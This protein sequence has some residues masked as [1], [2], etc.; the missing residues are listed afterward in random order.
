[1]EQMEFV[2]ITG[3]SGAGKSQA[4]KVFEDMGFFCVDNLPAPL[5]PKFAEL[6]R[7]SEGKVR[8]VALVIDIRGDL[9]L[10]ELN[11]SLAQ[12]EEM[13]VEYQILF[14]EASDEVLVSRFKETRRNHPLNPTGAIGEGIK[15]EREKLSDLRGRANQV[16]DTSRLKSA[17]LREEIRQQ[18][19]D[20][21]TKMNVTILSFGYKHGI[22]MDTD[23]LMDVRFI[24]NP[25]Y[26]PHLRAL[27]GREKP[28]QDYVYAQKET[29]EF[30]ERFGGLLLFLLPNYIKEGKTHMMLGIGCTGG[31][32]RSVAL[33]IKLGEI[34]RNNG[35]NVTVR[36]R[37]S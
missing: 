37:D 23:L 31:Q 6:C 29:E 18:W 26:I 30:L 11:D 12:L 16:L 14:L 32:H 22:P 1:M 10:D 4:I 25:F 8:S 15:L 34:L 13:K 20:Q 24:P 9:F 27:T 21:Q 19:G 17:Q 28:V 3:L 33:A 35:Y 5:I 36:H 2:I 7:Q